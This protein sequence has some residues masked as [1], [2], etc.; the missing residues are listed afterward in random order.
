MLFYSETQEEIMGKNSSCLEDTGGIS[1]PYLNKHS[2]TW[3]SLES[4]NKN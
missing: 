4:S 1:K 2:L 3:F